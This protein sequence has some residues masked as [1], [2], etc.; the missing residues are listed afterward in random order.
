[1]AFAKKFDFPD[2]LSDDF[3][4]EIKTAS[5]FTEAPVVQ[6]GARGPPEG[7]VLEY[8][9]VGSGRVPV[10]VDSRKGFKFIRYGDLPAAVR[11]NPDQVSNLG[12][13]GGGRRQDPTGLQGILGKRDFEATARELAAD[14]TKFR[15][16]VDGL[17]S[18]ELR[19]TDEYMAHGQ[20]DVALRHLNDLILAHGRDPNL[21]ARKALAELSAGKPKRAFASLEEESPA[22][23]RNRQAFFD[24]VNRRI[25]ESSGNKLDQENARHFA[26]YSDWQNYRTEAKP[27]G[28]LQ[29]FVEGRRVKLEYRA[30][31][32]P[33]GKP[34]D[35][36]VL[37][38]DPNTPVYIQDG[39]GINNL[40][41][42]PSVHS[43]L[44]ELV[45]AKQVAIYRLDLV[46]LGHFRPAVVFE[47]KSNKTLR[48][49]NQDYLSQRTLPYRSLSQ[50][51]PGQ[52]DDEER[53]RRGIA[54]IVL[55]QESDQAGT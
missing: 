32:L 3:F 22:S 34:T 16:R 37:M 40:D 51:P 18:E 4:V 21:L 6:L 43:S 13:P 15:S 9:E 1:V 19:L 5:G 12:R 23:V 46:D 45:S 52:G 35:F 7:A 14:P 11:S 53:R 31:E 48:L 49:A 36:E 28:E 26:E 47:T 38:G 25:R 27:F 44:Q 29:P 20:P 41:W 24:E 8:L 55:T 33:R 54:Y 2:N 42:N 39:A 17:L 50:A 10:H 30:D